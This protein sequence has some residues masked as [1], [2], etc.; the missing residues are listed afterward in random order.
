MAWDDPACQF[1]D[2]LELLLNITDNYN[3][4]ETCEFD[5]CKRRYTVQ[6]YNRFLLRP[7]CTACKQKNIRGLYTLYEVALT[8]V[9]ACYFQLRLSSTVMPGSLVYYTL[10]VEGLLHVWSYTKGPSVVDGHSSV[11]TGSMSWVLCPDEQNSP[12]PWSWQGYPRY[13]RPRT[14][15]GAV[16][17][18]GV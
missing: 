2:P 8:T 7:D 11:R 17:L 1:L 16:C 18:A 14:P 3:A 12:G 9:V 13:S 10:A 4:G 5:L 6:L 15:N